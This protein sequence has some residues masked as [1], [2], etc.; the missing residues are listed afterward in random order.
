MGKQFVQF[1]DTSDRVWIVNLANVSYVRQNGSD[2][3]VGVVNFDGYVELNEENA[4][5]LFSEMPGVET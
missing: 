5:K 4:K 2:W 1:S 3:E